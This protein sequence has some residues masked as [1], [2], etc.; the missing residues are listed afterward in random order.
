M[1]PARLSPDSTALLVID[2]QERL[3]PAMPEGSREDALARAGHLVWMAGELEMPVVATE[4]YPRGLGRTLAALPVVEPIE[5]LTFSAWD[6]P[7]FQ[8]RV[9][10]LGRRNVLVVGMETHIC[11]A[12]TCRDLVAAG[13][14]VWLVADACLSRRKLDHDLGVE[15]IRGDGARVVTAEAALFELTDTAGTPLFKQLS[16][17]LK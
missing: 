11:V 10:G 7:A 9:T 5:K 12:L 14:G 8:E 6:A 16:A 17:R 1:T 2:W 3:F 13:Y 4:Q 15:R